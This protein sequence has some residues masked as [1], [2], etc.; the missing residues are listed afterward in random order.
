MDPLDLVIVGAGPAGLSCAIE[1]EKA[2]L[3]YLVL[4]KG[5]L[6]DS[7]FHFPTNMTFFS[8]SKLLEI[9]DVPFISHSDK[10]TRR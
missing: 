3:N 4:E 6:V 2:K 8:T 7:I 5:M 10:P 9:G 1:A